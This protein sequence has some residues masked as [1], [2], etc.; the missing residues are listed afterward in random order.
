MKIALSLATLALLGAC[1]SVPQSGP[2]QWGYK[3]GETGPT[4]ISEAEFETLT[5]QI[6]D[7]QN[8]RATQRNA[9]RV[10]ADPAGRAQLLRSIEGLDDKIRMIEHRLRTANRPVPRG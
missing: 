2:A 10:T 1:A 7:L 5:Q 8:Q 3:P 6:T 9:V 4:V